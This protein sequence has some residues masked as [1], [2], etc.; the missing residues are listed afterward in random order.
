VLAA[1]IAG[2]HRAGLPAELI[3]AA[4]RYAERYPGRGSS[5]ADE[6]LA[7][8]PDHPLHRQPVAARP[9]PC[10]AT[11]GADRTKHHAPR[12]WPTAAPAWDGS[13]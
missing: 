3:E 7:G 6:L 9:S 11:S 10:P 1:A 2:M 4:E 5:P 13:R 8:W 12:R